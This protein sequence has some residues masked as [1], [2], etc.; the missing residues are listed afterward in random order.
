MEHFFGGWRKNKYFSFKDGYEEL[1]TIRKKII[2]P[3]TT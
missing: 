3:K 1:Q 2:V